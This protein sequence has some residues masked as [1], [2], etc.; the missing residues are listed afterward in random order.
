M[1]DPVEE[2]GEKPGGAAGLGT[3]GANEKVEHTREET[4]G[5]SSSGREKS[6]EEDPNARVEEE[7]LEGDDDDDSEAGSHSQHSHETDDRP[8]SRTSSTQSRPLIIVPRSKRRGLFARFTVVPEVE[9][10]YDYKGSTKWFITFTVAL[11]G[12]AAPFGSSVFYRMPFPP[13]FARHTHSDAF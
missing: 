7:G 4:H 10:P 8:I 9:R 13:F 3:D 5:Q 6:R 12:A 2:K 11:A 1:S